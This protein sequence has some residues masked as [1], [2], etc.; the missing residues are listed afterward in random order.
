MNNARIQENYHLY[1]I[2]FV[3]LHRNI[4]GTMIDFKQMS[5]DNFAAAKASRE[6]ADEQPCAVIDEETNIFQEAFKRGMK[7]ERKKWQK[8]KWRN[9]L[10]KPEPDSYII[11]AE[12]CGCG[13]YEY[14]AG[15]FINDSEPWISNGQN[16]RMWHCIDRWCYAEELSKTL[17][18]VKKM[19]D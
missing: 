16:C 19:E 14:I 5:D 10:E 7:H 6:W 4:T 17:P 9:Q 1:E 8:F 3:S 13:E 15:T 12:D 18:K 11:A 2:F